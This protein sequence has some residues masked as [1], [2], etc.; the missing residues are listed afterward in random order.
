MNKVKLTI[1]DWSQDG[2]NQYDVSVFESNK[3]VKEIQKAYKESCKKTGLSFNINEDYTGLGLSYG[4]ERQIATEYEEPELSELADEILTSFG[5]N[6]SE[7]NED[8]S[9]DNFEKLLIDF[10]KLSLPDLELEE[11]SFK[12]SELDKIPAINGWWNENLNCH[13][14]YGLYE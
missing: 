11:A 10:I 5:I 14:G 7:Y 13:F 1:G 12:K 2:H 4:S 3:T 6:T 8:T 9:P